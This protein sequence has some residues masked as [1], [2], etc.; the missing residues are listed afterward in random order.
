M[1]QSTWLDISIVTLGILVILTS[2]P[3]VGLCIYI[4]GVGRMYYRYLHYEIICNSQSSSDFTLMWNVNHISIGVLV[5][6]AA[7]SQHYDY[8]SPIPIGCMLGLSIFV[9][10]HA[11]K[12]FMCTRK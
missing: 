6:A 9:F 7:W 3:I 4:S 12:T 2:S 11:G 5:I 8:V 10:L 1:N